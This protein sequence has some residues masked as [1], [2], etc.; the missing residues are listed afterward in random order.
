MRRQKKHGWWCRQVG[1][2]KPY[3][4]KYSFV[5]LKRKHRNLKKFSSAVDKYSVQV[6]NKKGKWKTIDTFTSEND[7]V[8]LLCKVA[9]NIDKYR[10]IVGDFD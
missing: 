5:R 8:K 2:Y 10:H 1:I 7:A 3:A 4:G 9:N 6:K